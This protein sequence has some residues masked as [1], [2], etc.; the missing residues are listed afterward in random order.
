MEHRLYFVLIVVACDRIRTS[1]MNSRKTLGG[2]SS[3]GST[4]IPFL[5]SFL[6]IRFSA[7]EADWPALHTGTGIRLR[8]IDRIVVVVNW[9][10]ESGP[11]RIVSPACTTPDLTTPLTTV[12]TN[13]TENVSLT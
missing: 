1:A 9:P 5:T 7:K 6:R 8:S 10:S 4:T 11:I 13:G 3:L 12:P 2:C